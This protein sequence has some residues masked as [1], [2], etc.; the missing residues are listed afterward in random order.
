MAFILSEVQAAVVK[1]LGVEAAKEVS[2]VEQASQIK[3]AFP[4]GKLLYF[5][6]SGTI[7]LH[8]FNDQNLAALAAGTEEFQAPSNGVAIRMRLW[9]YSLIGEAIKQASLPGL[10]R[11]PGASCRGL[12]LRR[13]HH[14][15]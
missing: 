11:K 1:A 2:V 9:D 7:H 6:N 15:G 8:G 12:G 5:V 13:V 4:S 10:W 3:V 14:I